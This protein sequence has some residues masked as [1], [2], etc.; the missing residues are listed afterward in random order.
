MYS[1]DCIHRLL[2]CLDGF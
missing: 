1:T 2:A